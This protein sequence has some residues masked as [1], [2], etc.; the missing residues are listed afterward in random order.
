M[1]YTL[2]DPNA[3]P[4]DVKDGLGIYIWSLDLRSLMMV[5]ITILINTQIDFDDECHVFVVN[6]YKICVRLLENC[7][8]KAF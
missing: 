2:P 4:F 8:T 6:W 5:K 3:V 7:I 1:I